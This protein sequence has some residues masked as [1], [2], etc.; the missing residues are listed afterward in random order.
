LPFWYFHDH[1]GKFANRVVQSVDPGG[2][3]KAAIPASRIIGCVVYVAAERMGTAQVRH[4]SGNRLMLGE[5]GG[6]KT[7]RL[8]QL[9]DIFA[10]AGFD[11]QG[12]DDIRAEAWLKLWGNLA[13]NP[14]SALTRATLGA[15]CDDHHGRALAAPVM[16]E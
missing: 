7:E 10:R 4:L 14:I 8:A 1:G 3:V 5:L 9:C 6:E 2:I 12:I 16:R 13:F 15:I 11:A